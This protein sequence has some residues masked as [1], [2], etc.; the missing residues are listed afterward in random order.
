VVISPLPGL[1]GKPERLVSVGRDITEIREQQHRQEA[2]LDLSDR[3]RHMTDIQEI[4]YCAAEILARTLGVCRAGYGLVDAASETIEVLL[5]YHDPGVPTIAGGRRFREYGNYVDDLNRGETVVIADTRADPRSRDHAEALRGIGI[6]SFVNVPI[7]E[8]GVFVA[9]F[10][11]VRRDV[12]VWTADE[13]EFIRTVA[14]RTR[15]VT[16]RLRAQQAL[17]ALN[18]TLEQQVEQRTRERDRAWKHSQDL[19]LLLDT[20]GMIRAVNDVWTSVLGWT[21]RDLIGHNFIDFVHPDD[22]AM[23]EARVRMVGARYLP[24]HENRYRH[25]DGSYRWIAWVAT[26]EDDTIFAS[27]RHV[28]VEREQAEALELSEARLRTIFDGGSQA[29]GLTLPDGTVL[30]A[31]R[32]ALMLARVTLGDVVGAK[33]WETPWFNATPGMPDLIAEAVA[34]AAGGRRSIRRVALTCRRG[35]GFSISRFARC[36]TMRTR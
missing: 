28:T 23:S 13:I 3:L 1:D 25:K 21:P 30:K 32:V 6:R 17:E 15:L 14:D 36:L 8:Q 2:L 24:F 19:Q 27:G 7:I 18:A 33:L 20:D 16:E 5:D 26:V 11:V 22:R 4:A 29:Q 31:N 34:V 10:F 9:L 35:R 12:H